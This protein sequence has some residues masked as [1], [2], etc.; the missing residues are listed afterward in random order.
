MAKRD[1]LLYVLIL[2]FVKSSVG[3][4]FC[5]M[6]AT[7]IIFTMTFHD[8][9]AL[10]YEETK[11]FTFVVEILPHSA[12]RKDPSYRMAKGVVI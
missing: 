7:F 5:K 9:N 10:D 11:I 3:L 8:M 4:Y 1:Q 6:S 2:T 12:Q